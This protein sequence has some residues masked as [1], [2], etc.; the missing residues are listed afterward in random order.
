[1]SSK[2]KNLQKP[3][4]PCPKIQN[5]FTEMNRAL[6]SI[7]PARMD[8]RLGVSAYAE[9]YPAHTLEEQALLVQ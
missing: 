1:M 3:S 5:C 7:I 4:P 6:T 2:G 8:T 9:K